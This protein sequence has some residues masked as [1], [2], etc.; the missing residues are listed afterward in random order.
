MVEGLDPAQALA[1][2]LGDLGVLSYHPERG[3][4]L[5]DGRPAGVWWLGPQAVPQSRIEIYITTIATVHLP[6]VEVGRSFIA[7]VLRRA[8]LDP[9]LQAERSY[10]NRRADRRAER[11]ARHRAKQSGELPDPEQT[12]LT[13]PR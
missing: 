8:A 4:M 3:R 6:G 12:T 7:E 10:R 13:V 1:D 9:R 2:V 11:E 5:R